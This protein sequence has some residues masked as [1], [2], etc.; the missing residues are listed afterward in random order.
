L[1]IARQVSGGQRSPDSEKYAAWRSA[2]GFPSG[3]APGQVGR[4]V[5]LPVQKQPEKTALREGWNRR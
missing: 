5:A 1:A 4:F 3:S 2:D